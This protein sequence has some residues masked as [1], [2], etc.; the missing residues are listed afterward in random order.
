LSVYA[1]VRKRV[2]NLCYMA[3]LGSVM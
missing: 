3:Q 1:R 2:S